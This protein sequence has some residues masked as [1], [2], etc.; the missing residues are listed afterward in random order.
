MPGGVLGGDTRPSA[1]VSILQ[2]NSS[3]A[4]VEPLG[5]TTPFSPFLT[6]CVSYLN[7]RAR[8]ASA[9]SAHWYKMESRMEQT[10]PMAMNSEGSHNRSIRLQV[11]ILSL[12]F[13]ATQPA[14]DEYLELA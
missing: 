9:T 14:R 12:L 10:R 2:A 5:L 6:R 8:V 13:Q 1:A 4:K 3:R 7:Q 11:Q